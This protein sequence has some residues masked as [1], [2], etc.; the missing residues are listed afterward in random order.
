MW[1]SNQMTFAIGG[2][3]KLWVQVLLSQKRQMVACMGLIMS[4]YDA[5]VIQ[6]ELR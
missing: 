5:Y 3:Q 4:F 6:S 1:E 2:N